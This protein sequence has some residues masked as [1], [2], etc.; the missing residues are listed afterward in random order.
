MGKLFPFINERAKMCVCMPFMW[1]LVHWIIKLFNIYASWW[2]TEMLVHYNYIKVFHASLY[3]LSL[4]S[5]ELF[6]P[7]ISASWRSFHEYQSL[8]LL[9]NSLK[10]VNLFYGNFVIILRLFYFICYNRIRLFGIQ[11]VLIIKIVL[12]GKQ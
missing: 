12:C 11:N 7:Y 10:Q 3:S 9:L 1:F 6:S 5:V 8:F 2:Y 4:Y